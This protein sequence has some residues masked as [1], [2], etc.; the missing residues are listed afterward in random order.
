MLFTAWILM[1]FIEFIS[2]VIMGDSDIISDGFFN[3]F[4]T[5]SF[6][7]SGLSILFILILVYF[8]HKELN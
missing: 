7:I 6:L 2:A 3:I 4:K 5:I 8:Y 1:T